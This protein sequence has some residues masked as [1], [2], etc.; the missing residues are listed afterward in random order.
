M[1]SGLCQYAGR[2]EGNPR[3]A[4]FRTGGGT[5]LPLADQVHHGVCDG[6]H[7]CRFVNELQELL[8]Q[9]EIFRP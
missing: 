8:G 5:R 2:R 1:L 9:R 6:F 7:V 4:K 3:R